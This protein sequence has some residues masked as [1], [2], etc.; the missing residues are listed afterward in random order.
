MFSNISSANAVASLVSIPASPVPAIPR[1]VFPFTILSPVT[2]NAV[3]SLVFVIL[4]VIV[5]LPS[6]T[7]LSL[8][9][10]NKLVSIL[11]LTTVPVVSSI[12]DVKSPSTLPI[13]DNVPVVLPPLI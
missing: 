2:P 12:P 10:N 11:N 6:K 7:T 8:F 3:A 9:C 5:L 13:E 4:S 1:I